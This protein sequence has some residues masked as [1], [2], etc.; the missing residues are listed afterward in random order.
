VL[1]AESHHR[2]PRSTRQPL[3]NAKTDTRINTLNSTHASN[4]EGKCQDQTPANGQSSSDAE[5]S[6]MS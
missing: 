3:R 2:P 1:S 6:E 5:L 4:N